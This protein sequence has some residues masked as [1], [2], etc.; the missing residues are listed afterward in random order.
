MNKRALSI[1]IFDF[2]ILITILLI[3]LSNVI[4][5]YEQHYMAALLD[6]VERLQSID[7]PK[8]VLIGNSNWVFGVDSGKLEEY[9]GKPVVN[10]GM[11]GGLGNAFQ[12]EMAKINVTPGDIYVICHTSYSDE[13]IPLDPALLWITIENHPQLWKMVRK[14]DVPHLIDSFPVYLKGCIERWKI[15]ETNKTPDIEF[16]YRSAF[17]Q[18]GDVDIARDDYVPTQEEQNSKVFNYRPEINDICMNRINELNR[19]L[20]SKGATVVVA[21]YPILVSDEA[22]ADFV[23]YMDDFQTELQKQLTCEV[24]SEFENYFYTGNYF[25]DTTYHLTNKG[26]TLRTNQLISDL[27]EYLDE[28]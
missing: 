11:H 27:E 24:I 5:S 7:E 18:Y 3:F 23:K 8:I 10:M 9:F 1:L 17:N 16:Y 15:G 25:L 4:P 6:K 12:E 28:Y 26:V 19:Y 22:D 2:A 20:E 14:E 13:N 21:G